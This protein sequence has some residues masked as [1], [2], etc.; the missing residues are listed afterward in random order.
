MVQGTKG[1]STYQGTKEG[2]SNIM[3]GR[4]AVRQS[5]PNLTRALLDDSGRHTNKEQLLAEFN[6]IMREKN[7]DYATFT[8]R[9][10]KKLKELKLNE[11]QVPTDTQTKA[12][13]F[14]LTSAKI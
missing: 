4:E 9:Y 1:S 10:V 2:L 13:K 11:V 12:Y 5:T 6:T 7:E 3:R 8:T 14:L